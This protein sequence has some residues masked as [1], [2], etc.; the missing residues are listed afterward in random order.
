[1]IATSE[2]VLHVSR[3]H[4]FVERGDGIWHFAHI[5][6]K[7]DSLCG[8]SHNG[9]GYCATMPAGEQACEECFAVFV[10]EKLS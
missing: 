7:S 1:M 10:G 3:L 6:S 9:F 2:I 4:L 8:V 5:H